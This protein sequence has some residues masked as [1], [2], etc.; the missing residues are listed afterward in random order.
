[1]RKLDANRAKFHSLTV[2]ALP[3]PKEKVMLQTPCF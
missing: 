3:L 1:M 2:V